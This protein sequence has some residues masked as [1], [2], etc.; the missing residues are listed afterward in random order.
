MWIK[1]THCN[2]KKIPCQLSKTLTIDILPVFIKAILFHRVGLSWVIQT[3][4]IY[5]FAVDEHFPCWC[6]TEPWYYK[7]YLSKTT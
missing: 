2:N 6:T 7:K 3:K 4:N 1:C 5:D